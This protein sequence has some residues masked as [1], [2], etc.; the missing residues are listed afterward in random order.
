MP[1][2]RILEPLVVDATTDWSGH[3]L[4]QKMI[5]HLFPS[6]WVRVCIR[7]NETKAS[8]AVYFKIT[9][10]KDGTFWGVAQDTY[11]LSDWIGLEDGAQMTFRREH[12]NEIPIDWQPRRFR[13]AVKGL[14]ER[15]TETGYAIT[16]LRGGD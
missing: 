2:T 1:S 14:E 9:K 10:I 15:V 16:G 12:I 7:N 11:R 4:P 8:E 3:I 6:C 5:P 13:K